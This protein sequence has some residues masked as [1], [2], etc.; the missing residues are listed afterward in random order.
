M[1]VLGCEQLGSKRSC[2]R[3][4]PLYILTCGLP[5]CPAREGRR[6]RLSVLPMF[7][8]VL[9]VSAWDLCGQPCICTYI[10]SVCVCWIC[11]Q[12]CYCLDTKQ[13]QSHI[14]R[15]VGSG[16]IYYPLAKIIL[17][18]KIK[19]FQTSSFVYHK[20]RLTLSSWMHTVLAT[21]KEIQ[22]LLHFIF[23]SPYFHIS[24]LLSSRTCT[25]RILHTIILGSLL[26]SSLLPYYW[27]CHLIVRGTA[28]SEL[29]HLPRREASPPK[30]ENSCKTPALSSVP[31]KR[32]HLP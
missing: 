26:S 17:L 2:C 13:Q 20:P 1:C 8:W 24:P 23:I 29:F 9:W 18:Q 27:T 16:T 28:A 30:T 15:A 14:S 3:D 7:M 4:P 32:S 25:R 19:Y 6:M 31:V 5:S 11:L 21:C 12:P 22:H 10:Y